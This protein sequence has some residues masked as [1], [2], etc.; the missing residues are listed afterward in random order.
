MLKIITVQRKEQTLEEKL[1]GS[2]STTIMF[3]LKQI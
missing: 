1:F 3:G 2:N